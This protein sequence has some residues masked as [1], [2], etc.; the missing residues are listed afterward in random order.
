MSNLGKKNGLDSDESLI[1]KLLRS[2]RFETE[3]K[4]ENALIFIFL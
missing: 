1:G 4:A 3:R 2:F